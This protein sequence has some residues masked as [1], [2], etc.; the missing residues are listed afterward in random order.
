MTKPGPTTPVRVAFGALVAAAGMDTAMT[1]SMPMSSV[2]SIRP[3]LGLLTREGANRFY[4]SVFLCGRA[5]CDDERPAQPCVPVGTVAVRPRLQVDEPGRGRPRA[6]R[7]LRV[8]LRP[9]EV[10][11]LGRGSVADDDPVPIRLEHT[12]MRTVGIDER[13]RLRCHLGCELRD[14]RAA[15]RA[16]G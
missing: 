4:E 13:D 9:D 11:V 5:A 7:R 3:S 8:H 2:R 10:E 15:G 6:D 1:A 16:D 12:D 14:D